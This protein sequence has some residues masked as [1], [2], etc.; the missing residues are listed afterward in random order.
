MKE[1]VIFKNKDLYITLANI[2]LDNKVND[3]KE[4]NNIIL[5]S[6]SLGIVRSFMRKEFSQDYC[7]AGNFCN[8]EKVKLSS[9]K[10]TKYDPK[11]KRV[12]IHYTKSLEDAF[13]L[14]YMF[15]YAKNFCEN[16]DLKQELFKKVF[17]S[18]EELRLCDYLKGTKLEQEATIQILN[19][20][21]HNVLIANNAKT[22]LDLYNHIKKHGTLDFETLDPKLYN[23][24]KDYGDIYNRDDYGRNMFGSIV[25]LYIYNKLDSKE[26][27]INEYI[28]L[29]DYLKKLS[30][31]DITKN[32]DLNIHID[33]EGL[34][35]SDDSISKLERVY[36]LEVDKFNER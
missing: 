11:R 20:L 14:V 6:E 26:L 4:P 36:K 27:S 5:K 8:L 35:I 7:L 32:L 21:K 33:N 18:V 22:Y 31:D 24:Y 10:R 23:Y 15:Y 3:P 13:S 28:K 30:I 25:A 9:G 17:P 1:T 12:C 34:H 19:N 2:I 16:K 29:R